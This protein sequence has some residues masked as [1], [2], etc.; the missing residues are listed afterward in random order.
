MATRSPPCRSMGKANS[1]ALF[2][3]KF[4]HHELHQPRICTNQLGCAHTWPDPACSSAACPQP[5]AEGRLRWPTSF[6][7][8]SLGLCCCKLMREL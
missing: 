1:Q 5:D 8:M 2:W 7:P 4:F 6:L 3:G